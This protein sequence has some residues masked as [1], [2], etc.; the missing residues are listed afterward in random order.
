MVCPAIPASVRLLRDAAVDFATTCGL[1]PEK[2][3]AV[4]LA[5]S[6]AASNAVIH[7]YRGDPGPVALTAWSVDRKLWVL[8][9]DEGCGCQTPPAAPGLGMGLALIASSCDEFTRLERADGGTEAQMR[10]SVAGGRG[11]QSR[12]SSASANSPAAPVFSTTK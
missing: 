9:T 10:F 7:G 11:A 8:V 4:R 12:A 1:S 5:V 3:D 6:E 2:L